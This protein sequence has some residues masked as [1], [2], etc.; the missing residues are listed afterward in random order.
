MKENTLL[1]M[2]GK[3]D[4]KFIEEAA[5]FSAVVI[6]QKRFRF[7][8][9]PRKLGTLAACIVLVLGAVSAIPLMGIVQRASEENAVADSIDDAVMKEA[10]AATNQAYADSDAL[11]DA[12]AEDVKDELEMNAAPPVESVEEGKKDEKDSASA[13]VTSTKN[14]ATT[15][16]KKYRVG[17]TTFY[18]QQGNVLSVKVHGDVAALA[19]LSI[20]DQ[21][22]GEQI[23]SISD[24]FW[25]ACSVVTSL[26]RLHI[27]AS[28]KSFG[29]VSLLP[30]SV[31]I[32]CPVGSP[33]D[34]FFSQAGYTVKYP[35]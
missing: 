31:V 28:V 19:E 23:V 11:Y 32:V 21:I 34:S 33:A 30:K 9:S 29:D 1:D 17:E 8:L 6:P 20:P 22:D 35:A 18:Y 15:A 5:D 2:V 7:H 24:A 27:P 4:D 16:S 3:I 14:Q 26:Q 25:R 13:S 12:E 10:V